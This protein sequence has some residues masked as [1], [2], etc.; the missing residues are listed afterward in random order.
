MSEARIGRLEE[1]M[2][3]I[4]ASLARL[5]PM[6][7]GINASLPHLATKAELSDLRTEL[8]TQLAD[9]PSRGYL[10]GVMA[11]MVGAQAVALA[12]AAFVFSII[13]THPTA[14]APHA[15]AAPVGIVLAADVP[16]APYSCR[17]L[18]DEQRKCEI[19]RAHV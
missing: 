5:E 9:K 18:Y 6:L 19:G 17:L 4:R 1:D 3:E 11:A 12:A 16:P 2:H 8:L 15:S 14:P 13:Q 10:W 7:A